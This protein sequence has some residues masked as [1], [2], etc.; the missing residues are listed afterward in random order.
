M[1]R[2]RWWGWLAVAVALFLGLSG[3]R[4]ARAHSEFERADPPPG[5]QVATAPPELRLIFTEPLSTTSQ[6][7]LHGA[8]FQPVAG[9][10]SQVDAADPRQLIVRTPPLAP[11]VYTVQWL[12]VGQDRHALRGSYQLA[13]TGQALPNPTPRWGIVVVAV[14]ALLVVALVMQRVLRPRASTVT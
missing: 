11:G 10:Q 4:L 5:A 3:E 7:Y 8:N 2:F 13:I 9:V 6:A 12:A 14:I 1:K